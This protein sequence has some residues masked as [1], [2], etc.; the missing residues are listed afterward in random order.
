MDKKTILD[1]LM[2]TVNE[3]Q[4]KSG[5]NSRLVLPET[6]PIED[7]PGFDSL[8]GLE[9]ICSLEELLK[10]KISDDNLFV[11]KEGD[12][13]LSLNEVADRLLELASPPS[14]GKRGRNK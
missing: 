5:E 11:T 9:V 10:R 1:L 2:V 4:T 14:G 12:R 7:L 6:V 8:R 3:I 13:L